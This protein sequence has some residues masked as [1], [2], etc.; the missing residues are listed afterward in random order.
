MLRNLNFK[1]KPPASEE[2]YPFGKQNRPAE[3]FR[4]VAS[5]A[6]QLMRRI[7]ELPGAEQAI[8]VVNR[9]GFDEDSE[10]T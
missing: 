10:E 4:M 5:S 7:I 2:V 6:A 8:A 3:Q 9:R 1:P